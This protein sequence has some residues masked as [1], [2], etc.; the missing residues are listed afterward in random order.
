MIDWKRVDDE[1]PTAGKMCLV[2]MPDCLTTQAYF[3]GASFNEPW[4]D[5]YP[6]S[7]QPKWWA[8][9]NTP[10]NQLNEG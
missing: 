9:L 10:V 2:F 1:K 6:K 4:G 5:E 8:A 3:S 7:K